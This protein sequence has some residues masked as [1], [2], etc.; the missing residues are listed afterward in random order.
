MRG[1]KDDMRDMR[2]NIREIKA[3]CRETRAKCKEMREDMRAEDRGI[4]EDRKES[5][6]ELRWDER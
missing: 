2:R 4:W 3:E 6:K 5:L 1:L